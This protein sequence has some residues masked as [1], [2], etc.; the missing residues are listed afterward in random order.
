MTQ[1]SLICDLRHS[2]KTVVI[3]EMITNK[4][5]KHL[6]FAAYMFLGFPYQQNSNEFTLLR[7]G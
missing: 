5:F 2:D 3:F 1:V 6:T 4:K 7:D